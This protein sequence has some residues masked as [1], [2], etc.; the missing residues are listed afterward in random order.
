MSERPT[1]VDPPI[2][3]LL[4]KTDDSKFTLVAVA[5]MRA[6][7]INDYY[8]NLG[9]RKGRLIPPQVMSKSNKSLSLA[10]QELEEGK[11]IYRRP[12]EEEIAAEKAAA[13]AEALALA[14][15]D[16][17]SEFADE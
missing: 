17:F 8:N 3:D 10:L 4:A 14:E 5:A 12:T 15:A 6:R 11:L 13:E 2:E 9:E 16:P 7:E 1:L